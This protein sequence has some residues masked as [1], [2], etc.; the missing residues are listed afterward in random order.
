MRDSRCS[1]S[2]KRGLGAVALALA[3]SGAATA[4]ARETLTLRVNDGFAEPGGLAA[5]VIRT[6]ATKPIS[7]GQLC[8]RARSVDR[9]AQAKPFAAAAGAAGEVFSALE[10]VKVFAKKKDALSVASLE[11]EASGQTIVVEFSSVS[12]SINKTDGPLAVVYFRVSPDVSPGDEYLIDIDLA[13]TLVFDSA[14]A[15][16]RLAPRNGRLRIRHPSDPYEAEAEGDKIAPGERAELGVETFEP[17]AMASGQIGFTY[18]PAVASGTPKVKMRRRHGKRKLTVDRS[19][20]GLVFVTFRSPNHSWNMVP[21]E[22]L[23]VK[24][25]TSRSV[26]VGT[27]SRVGIDASLTFFVAPSGEILPYEFERNSIRFRKGDGGGDDGN[28]D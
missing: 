7:Q 12:S 19:M 4:H 8:F 18:D 28:D 5:V 20:P 15:A 3:V 9:A 11:A 17:V 26:A 24:L 14:G 27:R 10:G 16:I 6:Y 21:G 1:E 23:T 13:N 25:P 2:M 22:I